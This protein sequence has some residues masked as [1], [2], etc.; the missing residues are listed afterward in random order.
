[1]EIINGLKAKIGGAEVEKVSQFL[2]E[3]TMAVSKSLDL[4]L[5]AMLGGLK[6]VTT[7]EGDA[8]KILKV[9][10]DGGHSGDL[11]DDLPRLFNNPDKVQLLITI[12][13]NINNHFFNSKSGVLID[14][15][16]EIGALSKTSASS[17]FS[18]AA[19]LILGVL[20]K[21]IKT[22]GLN[23][24]GFT[25]KL[26]NANLSTDAGTSSILL[27]SLGFSGNYSAAPKE[28]FVSTPEVSKPAAV[29]AAPIVNEPIEESKRSKKRVKKSRSE[30][31]INGM[32]W[33]FLALLG[34]AAMYYTFKDKYLGT[35]KDAQRISLKDSAFYESERE[36]FENLDT[37]RNKMPPVSS[38]TNGLNDLSV[39]E[40]PI[41]AETKDNFNSPAFSSKP[42]EPKVETPV[43]RTPRPVTNT[44]PNVNVPSATPER[45]TSDTRPMAVKLS[46]SNSFSG[47]NG[48]VFKSNSAE[49]RSKGSLN[50][51]VTYL[52]ANPTK[53]IQIAGTG[54][55]ARVAEDRAYGLQG[56]LYEAG[57]STSRIQVLSNPVK[58]DGPVVVKVK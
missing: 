48:L 29:A 34:L 21:S 15:I 23:L 40:E 25:S 47:I 31:P 17:L 14:K 55:S 2:G 58:G 12:G 49:I 42:V 8:A 33:V 51:V 44:S 28:A 53:S 5:N 27:E 22:E 7:S 9:I 56:A 50:D 39:K 35:P 41:A 37:D 36:M 57:I 26:N 45:A 24:E 11:T 4:A 20:G 46:D 32:A 1:M 30:G 38:S 16:S 19:P 13:K 3:S 6:G 43:E 52:K 10:N 18:L 54:S